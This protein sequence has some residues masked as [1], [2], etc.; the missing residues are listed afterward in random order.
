L[1]L[2]ATFAAAAAITSAHVTSIQLPRNL[3]FY[4]VEPAGSGVLLSGETVIGATCGFVRVGLAPLR[5]TGRGLG[6]CV[7]SSAHRVTPVLVRRPGSFA[8]R[9]RIARVEAA[10]RVVEGPVVMRFQE[11]VDTHLA[12]AYGPRT[13]WLY[14][15]GAAAGPEVLQVSAVTGRVEQTARVPRLVRPLLAADDDGLWLAIPPNGTAPGTGASPL[16]H[17]APNART[18]VLVRRGGRAVLWLVAAGR[19]VWADVISKTLHGE[20]WRL[21]GAAGTAHALASFP[22]LGT[23]TAVPHG[24]TLWTLADEPVDQRFQACDAEHVIRV[25]G[26]TGRRS[27]VASVPIRSRQCGTGTAATFADGALEF[28]LGSRLYR[29]SA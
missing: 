20:I 22:E 1:R 18:A 19:S 29:V 6:S 17:V 13:L 10:G 28:V 24:S 3:S 27:L 26:A 4:D 16:Y 23:W 12:L 9:V 8:V 5:I 21:D 25:D 2:A 11:S 14:E 15:A 7:R